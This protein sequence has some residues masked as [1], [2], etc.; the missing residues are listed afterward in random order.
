M[1]SADFSFALTKEL[2]PG[3]VLFLS[4]H[5][6]RLYLARLDGL[7]ASL[8]PASL[9]PV[10]GLSADSCSYGQRFVPRFLRLGRAACAP[11]LPLCGSL[12]LPPSVP[13][14]TLQ[15][16]RNSPC[17]AHEPMDSSMGVGPQRPPPAPKLFHSQRL[18]TDGRAPAPTGGGDVQ[19][20][21]RK[22]VVFG[23]ARVYLWPCQGQNGNPSLGGPEPFELSAGRNGR[24]GSTTS[25]LSF[26]VSVICTTKGGSGGSRTWNKALAMQMLGL[27]SGGS[28]RKILY[29]S[30]DPFRQCDVCRY[31]HFCR[32]TASGDQE[33]CA[34][35][36]GPRDTSWIAGVG[37]SEKQGKVAGAAW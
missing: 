20:S 31:G 18:S 1:A 21:A 16:T 4:L 3:K 11:R 8:R 35:R 6:V 10:R 25:Q 17:W 26:V 13:V 33:A 15:L 12:R 24:Q 29:S 5:T 19:G 27:E 36:K 14:S 2:S 34:S 30:G 23:A 37:A 28:M 32:H 9:P 7:W 22:D